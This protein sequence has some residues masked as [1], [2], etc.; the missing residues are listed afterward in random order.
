MRDW[1]MTP[2]V[3]G[4]PMQG[5][6]SWKSA[7]SAP[8]GLHA[9]RGETLVFLGFPSHDGIDYRKTREAQAVGAL[10]ADCG[11]CNARRARVF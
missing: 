11:V 5:N 3:H 2:C 7:S 9:G 4:H 6:P 1:T 8:V 10:H